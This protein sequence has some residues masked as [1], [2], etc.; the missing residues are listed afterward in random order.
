MKHIIGFFV[1][2]MMGSMISVS[3]ETSKKDQYAQMKRVVENY[4]MAHQ[5]HNVDEMLAQYHE[6]I[7]IRDDTFT[8]WGMP[9]LVFESKKAFRDWYEPLT[10][11]AKSVRVDIEG[12]FL[13]GR[14]AVYRGTTYTVTYGKFA[15][16]PELDTVKIDYPFVTV[17]EF[18]DG[19]IYRQTDYTD[20]ESAI[21]QINNQ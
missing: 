13:A 7:L 18:K 5:S 17:F 8:A 1:W 2:A 16:R 4:Y 9:P 15:N 11:G 21:D 6:D 19:L 14:I 10:K 12:Y 20:Y 3:A